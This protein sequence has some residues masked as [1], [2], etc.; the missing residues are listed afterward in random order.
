AALALLAGAAPLR[1]Q[2]Q[3]TIPP[4]TIVEYRP[5]STLVVPEHP[6]PRPRYPVVDFHGHPRP[7]PTSPE[8]VRQ[9]VTLMDSIGIRVMVQAQPSSGER[10]V[11][12]IEA[13]REAGYDDR[14]V[15]FASLDLS[16]VGPGSGARI[17]AQL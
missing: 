6:V 3:P 17:A 13:V 12:Q 5:R 4:P 8:N 16:N 9:L 1:A 15:F 14:F 11:R 7:A 2:R 10:L